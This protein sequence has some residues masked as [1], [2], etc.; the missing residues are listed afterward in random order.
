MSSSESFFI[1][2]NPSVHFLGY[3]VWRNQE[4][5]K[6]GIIKANEN[7]ANVNLEIMFNQISALMD[8]YSPSVIAIQTIPMR[9]KADI[10]RNNLLLQG[11]VMAICVSKHIFVK[12]TSLGQWKKDLKICVNV[13]KWR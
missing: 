7:D 2:L 3:S 12:I 13:V 10:V 11:M 4:L 8:E 5:F 6:H 9:L 1:T